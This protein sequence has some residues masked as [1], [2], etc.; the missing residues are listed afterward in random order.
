MQIKIHKRKNINALDSGSLSDLAF[1]L[2]VFFIVIAVFNVN[3]GFLMDLPK[4]NSSKLVNI[5]DIIKIELTGD[6][7]YLYENS[8]ISE[9]DLIN[10]V[11]ER[12]KER[13]NMTMFLSIDP[14]ADYQAVV[15]VIDIVRANKVENFSFR[16]RGDTDEN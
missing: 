9:Q 1:L 15:N 10:I 8:E 7:K 5:S 3:M 6:E 11:K 16:M 13:P 2:I 14:M 4:K 12:V